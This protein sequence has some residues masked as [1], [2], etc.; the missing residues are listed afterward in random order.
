MR[1]E[2]IRLSPMFGYAVLCGLG[3]LWTQSPEQGWNVLRVQIPFW[4]LPLLLLFRPRFESEWQHIPWREAFVAGNIIVFFL[5]LTHALLR[6][7]QQPNL[8]WFSYG[9]LVYWLNLHPAYSTW[10]AGTAVFF[11]FSGFS[12]AKHFFKDNLKIVNRVIYVILISYIFLLNSRGTVIAFI[13]S[14][15]VYSLLHQR[16]KFKEQGAMQPS[17]FRPWV[18]LVL[19]GVLVT[20]SLPRSRE[21]IFSATQT[22]EVSAEQGSSGIRLEIWKAALREVDAQSLIGHGTGGVKAVLLEQFSL[23]SFDLGLE[24]E[25]NAHNQ[26]LQS[27]LML[28]LPG[29]LLMLTILGIL[30]Q[31]ARGQGDYSMLAAWLMLVLAMMSESMLER[32]MGVLPFA[33][34]AAW[35]LTLG[36]SQPS[37]SADEVKRRVAAASTNS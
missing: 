30:F 28:G 25:F 20:L 7:A 17:W 14:F 19:V 11:L 3:M 24:A 29:L 9:E 34:M 10:Y 27:Y 23:S 1:A 6:Y 21:R 18:V 33:F 16:R 15:A 31:R 8:D 5:C 37:Q 2:W 22:R 35:S 13:L 36:H 26:Y 4:L 12:P 32:Q